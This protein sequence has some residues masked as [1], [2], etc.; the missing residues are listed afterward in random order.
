MELLIEQI[1]LL[2]DDVAGPAAEIYGLHKRA[3]DRAADENAAGI[4][5]YPLDAVSACEALMVDGDALQKMHR[6][7]VD[8]FKSVGGVS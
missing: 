4:D 3:E 5:G 1:R 2:S 8:T 7:L 6:V